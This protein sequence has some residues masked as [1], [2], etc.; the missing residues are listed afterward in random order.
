RAARM[1]PHSLWQ[2]IANAR[3]ARYPRR[4]RIQNRGQTK[5]G[6]KHLAL[7]PKTT[8]T[9]VYETDLGGMYEGKCEHVLASPAMN[10]LRGKVQLIFT[11]PPFPL[12]R[13]K[14]YG[15]M[16]G[17][18]YVNW[19]GKLAPL[20]RE[21]LTPTGSIVIELGNAWEEGTPTMSTL[22]LEA[23]LKFKRKGELYL[24][25]EFICFNPA[26]LPTPTQWVNV[27][28]VRVKDSFTRLW[29]LSATPH[30]KADNRK[31]LRA[32]SDSMK[33]LLKNKTY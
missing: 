12:N 6:R 9:P 30:P 32:Y 1:V 24:C 27:E 7:R 23:L 22:S 33:K 2:R 14:K 18:T 8:L 17:R 26:R 28:R 19:L 25:Q 13:K 31:V 21:F 11:S 4:H 3:A 10:K 16:T 5:H 20:F 29:W 15:N